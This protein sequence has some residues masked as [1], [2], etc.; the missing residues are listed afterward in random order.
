MMNFGKTGVMGKPKSR[1]Q[2]NV[3]KQVLA[4]LNSRVEHKRFADLNAFTYSTAGSIAVMSQQIILGDTSTQRDGV[5]I[6]PERLSV[7]WSSTSSATVV[8]RL[9]VF[10]DKQA[11]GVYPAITDV[12]NTAA[13]LSQYNPVV[14]SEQKRFH[15]L[16]DNFVNLSAAGTNIVTHKFSV[17]PIGPI[18][19][20]DT[21]SVQTA[22]GRNSIYFLVIGPAGT[23]TGTLTYELCYTD[24]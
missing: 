2:P 21:T 15:V 6:R 7:T 13:T 10:Q 11:N 12:L 4:V 5:Q 18:T 8:C 1:G 14:M 9:V 19:F 24:S 3:R 20:L 17:K 16:Y 23:A 22:N